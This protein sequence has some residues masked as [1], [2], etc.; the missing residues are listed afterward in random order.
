M[1]LICCEQRKNKSQRAQSERKIF[2][3]FVIIFLQKRLFLLWVMSQ[4]TICRRLKTQNLA[5]CIPTR[6]TAHAPARMRR[7]AA[8]IQL[9]YRSAILGKAGDRAKEKS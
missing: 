4:R 5:C 6:Q 2:V 7:R 8:E 3:L 1:F 9:L